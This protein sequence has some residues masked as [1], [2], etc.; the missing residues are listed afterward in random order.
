MAISCNWASF[1]SNRALAVNP[2]DQR[3]V[4][5][6]HD[7]NPDRGLIPDHAQA[8]DLARIA[9]DVLG[10]DPEVA[11]WVQHC[12]VPESIHVDLDHGER[13]T[14]PEMP[15]SARYGVLTCL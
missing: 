1:G 4:G 15:S 13:G 5:R 10:V 3:R 9:V 2:A 6:L 8:R 12:R 7:L 11:S 14:C